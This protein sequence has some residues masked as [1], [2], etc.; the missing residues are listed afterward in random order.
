MHLICLGITKR[1]LLVWT[2]GKSEVR[3]SYQQ[4]E[5]INSK[6]IRLKSYIPDLFSRKPST[7]C[8]MIYWKATEY[9]LFLLYIEKLVLKGVLREDLYQHFLC[10]SVGMSI[11]IS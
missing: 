4:K 2:Q 6:I 10:L 7:L 3:L 5:Q 8:D 9:R 11:L 1:L